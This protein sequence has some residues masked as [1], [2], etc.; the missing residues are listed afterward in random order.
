[1]SWNIGANVGAFD[2]A[3]LGALINDRRECLARPA[4]IVHRDQTFFKKR[5]YK[6]ARIPA[7]AYAFCNALCRTLHTLNHTDAKALVVVAC[8]ASALVWLLSSPNKS[9]L[10]PRTNSVQEII[11]LQKKL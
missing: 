10:F 7:M 1:F 11:C 8:V 9:I 6:L 2:V 4:G 5:S 3:G